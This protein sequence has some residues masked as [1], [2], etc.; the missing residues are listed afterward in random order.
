MNKQQLRIHVYIT[1]LFLVVFFALNNSII[2]AQVHKKTLDVQLPGNLNFINIAGKPTAYYE[3][4]LTNF[5]TDT[6]QIKKLSILNIDDTS[7]F[8]NMQN[9]ELKNSYRKIDSIRKDTTMQLMPGNSAVIYVELSLQKEQIKEIVHRI[10]FEVAGK[11]SLGEVSIQTSPSKCFSNTQLVL[12]APLKGGFWAAVYEPSWEKGHRRVIYTV[13]GKARIPGRF[14]IDFIEID[15][16]GK[17][18]K[19]DENIIKNWLGYKAD[20]LAVAEGI[21][22][23]VRDDFLEGLTL[24]GHPKYSA[25]KATGNYVSI[26]IGSKQFAFYEHL[27]PQSIKVKIGQKVKKGDVIA[28]LGFTGQTTG[29]HLHF[30]IAD[31]DSP[32]G[33]EGIPFVF[34]QFALL[35]SYEDFGNLGKARWEPLN[36]LKQSILTKERPKPNAVI[37]FKLK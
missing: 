5:S 26:K 24:S 33:A 6:F 8:F 18:A 12:G 14:A 1:H 37:K 17:Y 16:G 3:L 28:S 15:S 23:S 4:Y 20:V 21:V 30:H 27:K 22:S 10:S 11:K 32:L 35:G 2:F 36:D 19:G 7:I 9:E 31:Y 25:D 34:E 13:N 29:P